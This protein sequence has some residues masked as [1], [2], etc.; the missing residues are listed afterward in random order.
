MKHRASRELFNHWNSL[1]GAR[2]AP[3]RAEINP[4]AIRGALSDT[5]ILA[6]DE[7]GETIFRLAGT[8]VCALFGR[9]LKNQP[10]GPLWDARSREDIE[11]LIEHAGAESCG[12]VAGAEALVEDGA[13]VAVEL[14]VLPLFHRGTSDGRL[15]G[16]LA[17][18]SAPAWLGLRTVSALRLMSWRAVGPQIDD[19]VVPRFVDLPDEP[20]VHGDSGLV[21]HHGGRP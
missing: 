2:L 21:I 18:L 19:V 8:R 5:V 13:P 15:I 6:R 12:V 17:P 10:F 14:L 20:R 4:A 3:E 16:T 11:T 1:R 9:E 7:R